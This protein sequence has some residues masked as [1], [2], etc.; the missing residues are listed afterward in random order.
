MT[1]IDETVL[2]PINKLMKKIEHSITLPIAIQVSI[3]ILKKIYPNL[4]F[5]ALYEKIRF[6]ANPSLSFQKSDIKD[7]IFVNKNNTISVEMTLNFLSIFGASS[8][9]P[10]HYSEKILRD[11][12]KDKVLYDFLNILNH[13]IM[14]LINPV[15]AKH[16]YY[17]QYR[18]NLQDPLSKYFLSLVGLYPQSQG[19]NTFL[20][21]NR[22]MP[23]IASLGM[24]Q[25]SSSS[26]LP[27]L[28]HYFSHE[29]IEIQEGVIS[30][31]N[32]SQQQQM[33]I[34]NANST[35]G[36][37]M[38]IGT[39]I[40]SRTLSFIISFKGIAWEDLEKFS[41][42]GHKKRELD[43]LMKILLN[44]P[45]D[46]RIS[47]TIAKEEIQPC[48]LGTGSM[49]GSNSWIGNVDYEQTITV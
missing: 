40:L 4:E 6:N 23:F 48:V 3:S 22:L 36:Q 37:D 28:R 8:P 39:F 41:Y 43:T 21:I 31:F 30:R 25:K 2:Q 10:S 13:R 26:I 7:I 20:N 33:S 14:R 11:S 19:I 38:H 29:E 35:L 1:K 45:L 5:D 34:G 15:W 46:Y 12:Q 32:I 24:L 9:I 27:I 49:L 44:T 42:N 18:H 16:R 17:I 47:I